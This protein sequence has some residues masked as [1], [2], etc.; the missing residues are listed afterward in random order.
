MAQLPDGLSIARNRDA[1]PTAELLARRLFFGLLALLFAVALAGLLGQ[2][3][4]HSRVSGAAAELEVSAPTRLRGGLFFQGRFTVRARA[5]LENATLVLAAGWLESMHINTI[6]PAPVEEASR[7]GELALEYGP[8]GA[9]Q[10]LVAYLQFQV[11]PTNVARRSQDVALYDGER[12]LA[13]V[14]RTV[15]IYP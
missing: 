12:L 8:L 11:N 10:V 15:T 6:A 13:H 14:D 2:R 7:V 1:S 3:P 5:D 9:G 4:D